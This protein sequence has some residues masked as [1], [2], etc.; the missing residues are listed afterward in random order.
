M[1]IVLHGQ[2]QNVSYHYSII[3]YV[4]QAHLIIRGFIENL[5]NGTLKIVAQGDIESLKDLRRFI[6][7]GAHQTFI[8]DTEEV[9]SVIKEF[10]YNDFSIKY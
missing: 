9:M 6:V 2:V 4:D 5:P 8:R 10:T 7:T 3:N 1:Q